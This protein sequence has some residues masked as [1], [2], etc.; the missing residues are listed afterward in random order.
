MHYKASTMQFVK[1]RSAKEKG[2]DV[3][4]EVGRI[5]TQG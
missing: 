4:T 2:L 5:Q 1:I 3:L